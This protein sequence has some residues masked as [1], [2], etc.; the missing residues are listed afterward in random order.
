MKVGRCNVSEELPVNCEDGNEHD[1]HAI[2]VL[3]DGETVG[4]LPRKI[5][6]FMVLSKAWW[7][8]YLQGHRKVNTR[9]WS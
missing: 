1:E 4:H 5:L 7:L 3:K 8:Y 9:S 6:L 2:A